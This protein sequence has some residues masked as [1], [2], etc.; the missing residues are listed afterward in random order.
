MGKDS[1][2][3]KEFVIKA[4]DLGGGNYEF[5]I[6]HPTDG[7]ELSAFLSAA[8]VA[9]MGISRVHGVS[10]EISI[11][12]AEKVGVSVKPDLSSLSGLVNK[13]DLADRMFG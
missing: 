9:M 2:K 11:M 4:V 10:E 1:Q 12:F 8:M 13:D 3:P 6:T 7:K 5:N